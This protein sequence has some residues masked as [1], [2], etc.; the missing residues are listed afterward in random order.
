MR[1]LIWYL[2]GF[3]ACSA[4]QEPQYPPAFPTSPVLPSPVNYAPSVTPNIVDAAAPCAQTACPGYIASNVHESDT[5]IT[6]DLV[7]A[8]DACNVY[9]NDID[10]LTLEVEYQN[11]QQSHVRI[12]P[13]YL[14]PSNQSLYF[15]SDLLTPMGKSETNSSRGGS[16]LKFAWSN[17]PSFQFQIIRVSS[18]DI[19]FD[20]YGKKLVFEDQFLEISTS[21]PLD[22]NVYGLAGTL[23]GFRIPNN[24]TQTFWNAYNLD[25]D[26]ELDVNGH[27]VHPMYLETRYGSNGSSAS[28]GVYA[29]NA[30]GQ[31]WLFKPG[32]LT[33]RTIGGS[34]DLYFFSGPT[35]K[36]V[37]SQYQ[38]GVIRTPVLQPY[39]ALGFHQVRW[40]YQ[41]WTNLQNVIDLYAAENIQLEG[42]M[43]DLDYLDLNRIF[44]DNPGHYDIG[45]GV[46]F[47]A[48]LHAAGQYY[49]PILDPNVY[50]PN[51]SESYPTYKRGAELDAYIRNGNES[52][53]VGVEWPG[54][55]VWPDFL[56]PQA[57]QFWTEQFIEFHQKLAFD[58][59]WLDVS[60]A[61]S[62]CTGSCG[63][64]LIEQ[65]PIHVPFALP[66]DPDTALAVD[67]RYPEGFSVTNATEAAS[68]SS[69]MMSQS[70]AYPTPT[71][72]PTPVYGRTLPT[73]GVRNL[74][75]PPYAINNFLPGHSLVKEVMSPNATHNDGPFNSTEY[76]L[77]NLYGHLSANATYHALLATYNNTRRPFFIARSTFAGSGN[78]TGHW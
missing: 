37:I 41:N 51:A 39:F 46:E 4:A 58:G 38:V 73:P 5:G 10:E 32:L 28:H 68:A 22:A 34:F 24:Y 69:A 64:N 35:P 29:R 6:A 27:D 63:Q 48:R 3:V 71:V 54:F 26:Q 12:Y 62:F 76:E 21:L 70:L 67:Y 56:V 61:V 40:S 36:E 13:K 20:T 7:L 25:N 11:K 16:D 30:H 59:F 53:Y 65:N 18:G 1:A 45:E 72:T 9:G 31:E 8:G 14:A 57:Q 19:L 23:R 60:D 2:L 15:L 75:F 50:V 78:F 43:N 44:T 55:S 74:N 77:H 66:G 49:M 47:L 52:F 33:Y 42:I 17:S